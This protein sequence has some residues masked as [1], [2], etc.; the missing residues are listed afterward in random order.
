MSGIDDYKRAV[1]KKAAA[2][3]EVFEHSPGKDVLE[4]LNIKHVNVELF[5]ADP[6]KM[7]AKVARHD[8]IM[9]INNLVRAAHVSLEE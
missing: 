2:Y 5:D 8:V 7:A 4:D 6:I 1:V 9:E 3:A